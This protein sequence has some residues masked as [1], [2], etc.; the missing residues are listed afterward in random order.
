MISERLV[1]IAFCRRSCYHNNAEPEIKE[2][3]GK[4]EG[5]CYI[6][7][8]LAHHLYPWHIP[9][10]GGGADVEET[11]FR[12]AALPGALRRVGVDTYHKSVLAAR[13]VPERLTVF[14]G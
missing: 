11:A 12:R 14:V 5:R 3:P 13:L 7:R 4:L 6:N 2:N 1:S 9:M 10:G 8:R